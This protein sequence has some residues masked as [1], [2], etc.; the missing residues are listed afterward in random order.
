[1]TTLLTVRIIV[2]IALVACAL[3]ALC[4]GPPPDSTRRKALL[5]K[6]DMDGDGRLSPSE[7]AAARPEGGP[8][9]QKQ[10]V[11]EVDAGKAGESGLRHDTEM[12]AILE[13]F[14]VNNDGKLSP[15]EME[16]LRKARPAQKEVQ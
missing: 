16:A 8:G 9:S 3:P 13:K 5:E 12:Q 4:Q 15:A 1:M 6:F 2:L 7:M 10:E 11:A 14:D